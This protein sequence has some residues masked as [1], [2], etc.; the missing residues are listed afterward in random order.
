M[1]MA[2][3]TAFSG[4]VQNFLMG[5]VL[6]ALSCT[7]SL[8][9]PPINDQPRVSD[10]LPV[11]FQACKDAGPTASGVDGFGL[12]YSISP[13]S[14]IAGLVIQKTSKY[15]QPMWFG[16]ALMMLGTGLLG[17]LDVDS[18]R[19]S[20]Y[21]YQV[22]IGVGIGIIYVAAYFPVLAPI[23]VNQSAPALAFFTFLRNFALVRTSPPVLVCLLIGHCPG[24]GCHHWWHNPTE[25]T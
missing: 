20:S 21:G 8:K 14:V 6:A 5:V 25:R 2:S 22:L 7:F 24:L 4:Y 19:A 10:W 18:S 13:T 16:W 1:L 17:T 23:P 11:F 12:S 9:S 15:R 3:R